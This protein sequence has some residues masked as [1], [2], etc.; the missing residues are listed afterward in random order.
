MS[1]TVTSISNSARIGDDGANGS[2]PTPANNI[3]SNGAILTTPTAITLVN[4]A[5]TAGS[6]GVSVTWETGAEVGT[7]GFRLLRSATG[8]RAEAVE[9]TTQL[10]AAQGRGQGGAVYRFRDTTARAGVV[11]SYWLV[12][13]E[14]SGATSEYGPVSTGSRTLAGQRMVFLPLVTR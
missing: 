11:Y 5:A 4:F 9:V 1:T 12:E 10:I 6:G 3:S 14:T 13:V 2:D 8:S 7:A